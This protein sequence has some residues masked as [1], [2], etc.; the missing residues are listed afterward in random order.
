MHWSYDNS[1][2]LFEDTIMILLQCIDIR[3]I[4]KASRAKI[5]VV[6]NC[7]RCIQMLQL[8]ILLRL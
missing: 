2:L 5:L 6:N 7:S 4:L 1:S 3:F 8:S